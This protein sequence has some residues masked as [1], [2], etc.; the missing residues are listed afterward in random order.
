MSL[1]KSFLAHA[2]ELLSSVSGL[3]TRPMFGGYGLY[4]DG[5]I[6]GL[7][8]DDAIYFKTDD[9]S[10]PAFMAAKCRQWVYPSPKGP[11]PTANYAPPPAALEDAEA[12]AKWAKLG[13]E[14]AR[15][16]ASRKG[17]AK[18]PASKAPAKKSAAKPAP[19]KPG[20]AMRPG[21]KTRGAKKESEGE[22]SKPKKKGAMK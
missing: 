10:R 12:M 16:A 8:D 18:K 6:F 5:L 4:A 1:S 9:E 13:I 20:D 17:G 2:Q 7:L 14:T 11:M 21:A 22:K 19:S 3:T 15:R